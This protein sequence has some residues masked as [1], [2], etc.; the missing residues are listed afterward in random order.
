MNNNLPPAVSSALLANHLELQNQNGQLIIRKNR[1]K[2]KY[3]RNY[4]HLSIILIVIGFL[5]IFFVNIRSGMVFIIA[6]VGNESSMLVPSEF[7]RLCVPHG[8]VATISDPH[9]IANVLY[10][11]C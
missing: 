5:M 11:V 9:E 8:T 4:W 3:I 6:G 7:A 10:T 2:N 1:N